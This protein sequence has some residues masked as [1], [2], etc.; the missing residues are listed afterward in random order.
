M[1]TLLGAGSTLTLGA[2]P[3]E[4][5][6]ITGTG[7]G[8]QLV[9]T[10]GGI[11]LNS[12]SASNI[13]T[14]RLTD[15]AGAALVDD[16]T[17]RVLRGGSGADT[18]T[19]GGGAD[20]ITGG[21]GRDVFVGTTA[22]LDGVT[23]TD[24]D[25]GESIVVSDLAYAS[26]N[27]SLNGTTLSFG[28]SS[29]TLQ[30]LAGGAFALSAEGGGAG[31]RI[32]LTG[33]PGMPALAPASDLGGS[34]ADRIT[35]AATLTFTGNGT[36]TTAGG[37]VTVFLDANKNNVYDSGIDIA[38]TAAVQSDGSWQVQ[39]L[40][41]AGLSGQYNVYAFGQSGASAYTTAL[42]A[43]Q[44]VTI[45][46]TAPVAGTPVRAD[47]PTPSGTSFTVTVSYTD[48]GAGLDLSTIG[49]NNISVTGP[50]G[51][52][53]AVSG[54][55][56]SSGNVTYT[57]QA[58][59]GSWD[60]SDYGSYT[61]AING[62]LRDLAGNA[63]AA[64]ANA[65]TFTV[66]QLNTAPTLGGVYATPAV[67]DATPVA[68]FG[69]V[70][71][72]DADGD[73]L[74]LTISYTAANGTLAG[75]G[76][77]G[78]AGS[79][80]LSGNAATIQAALRALTF[81]PTQ[82]QVA[83][84][85]TDTSFTLTVSDGSSWSSNSATVVHA[86]PTPPGAIVSLSDSTLTFGETATLTI[87][88]SEAVTGLTAA[89]LSV[90]GGSIGTPVSSNSGLTWT[91]TFTPQ[92]NHA[93]NGNQI[94]LDL[95]GVTDAGGT[96]GTGTA[97]SAS[98]TI[99]TNPPTPPEPE[100]EA[101]TDQILAGA[102]GNDVLTG[103]AGLDTLIGAGGDDTLIGGDGNDVLQGGS[104]DV[105]NW[106]FFVGADGQ[107]MA[108]HSTGTTAGA[109][110]LGGASPGTAGGA[111]PA[112]A[113]A[114]LNLDAAGLAFLSA[115]AAKLADLALL[116]AAAF[117]R[118]ADVAGAN[119]HLGGGASLAQ[120]A[121]GFTASAEWAAAGWNALSDSAF[122]EQLYQHVQGRAGDAAGV[123]FWVDQLAAAGGTTS[124][125]DVLLAF[126]TSAEHRALSG[127]GILGYSATVDQE[128]GWIGGSGNDR[129]DGGAG[130]DRPVGGDGIDTVVY[131]GAA[132]A[133]T[134]ALN[135]K[136][137]VMI[138]APDGALDTIVQIER[139]EFNGVT[140]DLGFTQADA[141]ALREVGMLYHLM[142]RAGDFSGF[143][144]WIGTGLRGSALAGSFMAAAEF[145]QLTS[146]GDTDF[147]TQLYQHT[148]AQAQAAGVLA[149]W[150]AYLDTH[151]RADLVAQLATD[152]TLVGS[153]TGDSGLSL[154]A[155][156]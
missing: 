40:S 22:G 147:I 38:A 103:A 31:T 49:T 108:S 34:S 145:K 6:S 95:S 47:M 76:L 37:T 130:A 155:G 154:I 61:V 141:G 85:S 82:N 129:L 53:L 132:S 58:P 74:T 102:A 17:A 144:F 72:A 75:T 111:T 56:S 36:A 139:G 43:A 115:P 41:T 66:G 116:Y 125:A 64:N 101:P 100:P 24:L 131:S 119:A 70:T 77:T 79:Y 153:Q 50:G 60:A 10:S 128:S 46:T 78:S 142:G 114:D 44:S 57:L 25:L 105:G 118:L 11:D 59:G 30:G 135:A 62:T 68:P 67:N 69:G 8:N 150:D 120:I 4:L 21:A 87:T 92:S 110:V 73:A 151:S 48:A 15:A 81:S 148:L 143:Q 106:T 65:H 83:S 104:S 16:S 89:H 91:A 52:T 45:D 122:V 99:N 88:F 14:I 33:T 98:Y 18:I 55:S 5:T 97:L 124:R 35:N 1:I 7:S 23:I 12:L 54:F 19:G 121:T 9:V 127:D 156:L 26:A 107:L 113:L 149:Q 136:G 84:G 63:V 32:T 134:L 94:T 51:N 93:S 86:T 138:G 126:A 42:G 39:G 137:E 140:L 109:P 96:A 13:Q 29:M 112:L 71:V 28:A 123:A 90:P 133:Y 20:T 3:A 146:L 2:V 117:G 152:V 27:V 80:T